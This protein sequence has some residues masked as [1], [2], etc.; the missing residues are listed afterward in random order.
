MLVQAE[1]KVFI[2]GILSEVDLRQGTYNRDGK[3]MRYRAGV[4]KVKVDLEINEKD[5]ELIIPVHMFGAE[6]NRNGEVSVTYERLGEIQNEF[7][8]IA[9]VGN[10]V[11]ADRV[12]VVGDLRINEFM[13]RSGVW[14]VEPR[15]HSNF[16]NLIAKENC[17]PEA[18]FQIQFVLA[19]KVF[20]LEEDSDEKRLHVKGI[21]P[22]YNGNV[23]IFSFVSANE[24]YGQA[25]DLNWREGGTYN[26]SGILDFTVNTEIIYEEQDFGEPVE[27]RRTIRKNDLIITGGSASDYEYPTDEIEAA[28][29]VRKAKIEEKKNAPPKPA[30]IPQASSTADLG[31]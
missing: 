16:V 25:I 5:V 24:K 30:A 26:I 7:K 8:S 3:P 27:R 22:Q 19:E 18:N 21:V 6:F 10:E 1:N 20:E 28:L 9:A 4:I 12:R 11:D 23:E 2:Q 13:T 31:F 14:V 29:K 17:T 15:V